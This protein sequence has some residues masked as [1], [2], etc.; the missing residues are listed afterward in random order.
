[1][2]PGSSCSLHLQGLRI[3]RSQLPITKPITRSPNEARFCPSVRCPGPLLV[4]VEQREF[5]RELSGV[6]II[7]KPPARDRLRPQTVA[8]NW[9]EGQK[10]VMHCIVLMGSHPN[11]YIHELGWVGSSGGAYGHRQRSEGVLRWSQRSACRLDQS[12]RFHAAKF[13]GGNPFLYFSVI[14]TAINTVVDTVREAGTDL[15]GF[16]Y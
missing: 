14:N 15:A 12:L 7:L 9:S 6:L 1:V 13:R 5:D 4:G 16:C 11:S 8:S 3:P 10:S 2:P